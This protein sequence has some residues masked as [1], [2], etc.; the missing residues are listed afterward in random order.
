MNTSIQSVC[1]KINEQNSESSKIKSMMQI[2]HEDSNAISVSSGQLKIKN[3]LL[4]EQVSILQEKASEILD[5][6]S[7]AS[8]NLEKMKNFAGKVNSHSEENL[9][10]SESVKKIVDSYKT[11]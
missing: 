10:L 7:T 4:E 2:L 11:E 8:E 9:E 1:E 5:G 3:S 6:S